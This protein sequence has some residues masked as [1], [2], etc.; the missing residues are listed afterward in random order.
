MKYELPCAIVRDLLPSY[1]ESLTEEET[2]T[3]V[4]AHLESCANCRKRYEAMT[5]GEATAVTD[6]KEVDY[7]KTV[8]KKNGKQ[9]I[10]AVALA[11]V[12][13]LGSVASYAFLIGSPTAGGSV[14]V[15]TVQEGNSVSVSYTNLDSATTLVGLKMETV[16]DTVYITA[17]KVLVSPFHSPSISTTMDVDTTEITKIIAFG[18]L[19]WQDG[20]S[21]DSHTN[22][23][24]ENR[25][26]YVG[27]APALENLI[28]F[29][30]LDSPYT[31]ELQTEKEPYGVTLHFTQSVD[32]NRR[33][34]IEG[35]AY[36]LLALVDNLGQ[37]SWNDPSGYSDTLTL[38]E[39]NTAIPGFVKSYNAA[40]DTNLLSLDSVKDYGTDSYGLQ[41]LQDLLGI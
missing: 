20:L 36:V 25:T 38:E 31:L 7:L 5:G 41:L 8:R 40:H 11:V 34:L 30:D 23:L 26:P 6:E 1:V 13:V 12:L 18:Q 37:V 39:A 28:F 17:R 33:F 32:E 4:Q 19:I 21:I 14:S 16:E 29:M 35:N 24:L 22:R 2:T 3:A 9:I 10:L 27:N 15:E